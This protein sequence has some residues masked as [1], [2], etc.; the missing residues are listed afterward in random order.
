MGVLGG[1]FNPPHL[2][3]MVCAQ[4]AHAQLDLDCVL[5]VPV[6]IP[7]HKE[8]LDDPGAQCRYQLCRAAVAGD[9]RF[10]VSA[11]D[12]G[13][14]GPSYTVDTLAALHVQYPESDLT[15]IAGGDMARSLP[16]WREPERV[17]ALATFAVAERESVG[18]ADIR[19]ALGG[20]RGA[21]RLCFFDMPRVDVSS[22][23][24]RRRIADGRP[25]RYLVPDAVADAIAVQGLYT[26][27]VGA[28]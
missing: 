15:F 2:G 23:M 6:A 8:L 20:V 25:V 13:R 12:V 21:D 17:L 9:E 7:P 22:S 4:E 10:A 18:R 16:T 14:G 24:I 19:D 3:H 27:A 26:S 5:L 28:A 11:V 1:T